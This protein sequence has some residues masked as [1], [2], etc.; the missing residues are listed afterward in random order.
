MI[1]STNFSQALTTSD[2]RPR[3]SSATGRSVGQAIG[4]RPLG[5][6]PVVSGS[7]AGALAPALVSSGSA[8]QM[9]DNRVKNDARR[10]KDDNAKN[11]T[12]H[13]PM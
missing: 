13:Y 5:P 10:G 4:R 6:L 8:A 9:A 11:R 2:P 1:S 7:V 12:H 3:E